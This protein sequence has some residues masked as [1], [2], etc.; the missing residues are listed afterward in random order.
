MLAARKLAPEG[1]DTALF[2]AGDE[3]ANFLIQCVRTDCRIAYTNGIY[4]IPDC[5]S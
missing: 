5:I 2:T 3:L 4:A 1:F